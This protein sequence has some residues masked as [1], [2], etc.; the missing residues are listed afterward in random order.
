MTIVGLSVP[1]FLFFFG[2]PLVLIAWEFY[3]CWQVFKG[4]RE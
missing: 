1:A 3:Y 4:K 2:L